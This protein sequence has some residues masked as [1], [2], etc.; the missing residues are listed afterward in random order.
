MKFIFKRRI[1]IMFTEGD[2][3]KINNKEYRLRFI[4]PH[5]M[6][7]MEPVLNRNEVECITGGLNKIV[8]YDDLNKLEYMNICY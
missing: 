8:R 6:C 5:N 7:W 3:F 1:E 2:I 4:N